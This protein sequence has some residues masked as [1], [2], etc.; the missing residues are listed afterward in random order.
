MVLDNNKIIFE[1]LR[2]DNNDNLSLI[3]NNDMMEILSY[4][5]KYYLEYRNKIGVLGD[6]S[7]GIEIEMEHFKG[8]VFDYWP[9]QLKINDIV[10]NE[11]WDI[12]NDITLNA[13]REIRSELLFDMVADWNKL[14]KV[15]N[16]ASLYGEIDINCGAHVHVGAHILGNNCLYWYRFFKLWSVYENV[17][18]RF[19]YGEY[20]NYRTRLLSHAKP[21]AQF[22]DSRMDIIK[23]KLDC[24]L[25]EMLFS[26]RPSD[27]QTE[28]LKYFGI[29]YWHMLGDDDYNLYEDFSKINVGCTIECRCNNGTFN[30]IIWQNYINF[31][32]KMLLYCKSDKFDEDIIDRR[33]TYVCGIFSKI[34]AY[35]KI[36]LDQALELSDMIFDNNLD[37]LYF[38]RQYLKSFEIADKPYIK[39]KRITV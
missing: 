2:P 34:D 23:D 15:C 14:K 24:S 20:L 38:L 19:S 6:I 21:A 33:K 22:L 26:I 5:D 3:N 39:A 25:N 8:S 9:F 13:G 7:F 18:Y 35:S 31:I 17:I 36:Y 11:K 12:V 30:E 29:S 28:K 37:K 27:I 32:I 16:F 4:L 10:G 1:Y